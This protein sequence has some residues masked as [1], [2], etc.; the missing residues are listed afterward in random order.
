MMVGA[1]AELI[2]DSL[3]SGTHLGIVA[4]PGIANGSCGSLMLG[5]AGLN[6]SALRYAGQQV[7]PASAQGPTAVL[8]NRAGV[9]TGG[10][11]ADQ[12]ELSGR[13]LPEQKSVTSPVTV[14]SRSRTDL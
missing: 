8:A 9:I 12:F 6:T 2:N 10:D 4:R 3:Q 7:R 1:N 5:G 13:S 11:Q 14:P